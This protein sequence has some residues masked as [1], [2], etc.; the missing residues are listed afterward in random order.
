MAKL[1]PLE[2][3][4]Q[5]LGISPDRL[6][7]MRSR[8]EVFGYRDGSSWK[9][10][11]EELERVAREIGVSLGGKPVVEQDDLEDL[12][13]ADDLSLEI[14][15]EEVDVTSEDGPGDSES[16]SIL[17]S[18]EELGKSDETTA[19]TIIGDE[20]LSDEQSDLQAG[21]TAAGGS[22]LRLQSDSQIELAD[23]EAEL[24]PSDLLGTSDILADEGEKPTSPS[25]TARLQPLSGSGDELSVEP[26][27]GSID[28]SL[29][30]LDEPEGGEDEDRRDS[31]DLQAGNSGFGSAI[32][33]ELDDD[34]LVLGSGTGSDVTSG[35]GDSGINLN[36]PSDSGL[37]LEEPLDLASGSGVESLELGEDDL[38]ELDQVASGDSASG[39]ADDDFLLT[40][41]ESGLDDEGE[42]G[43]QV[44]DLD[45][46]EFDDSA[47]A[48][49]SPETAP[50]LE[51]EGASVE[52]TEVGEEE[53]PPGGLAVP[54]PGAPTADA[55]EAPYTIWNVLSLFFVALLLGFTGIL[56]LDL[57]NNIWSWD[58]NYAFNSQI[59]DAILGLLSGG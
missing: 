48:L 52:F 56:M 37:S 13:G 6:T 5:L 50:V 33:L 45:S 2:D 39:Q 1:I 42:S 4:A 24:D 43:S 17:V 49:L 41:V 40:P 32:D 38:A 20:L 53:A 51:E 21:E 23:E 22:E 16:D 55:V 58:G 36:H 35:A 47:A 9:F 15:E 12:V 59:M 44:I 57:M 18:E 30:D 10:K 27:S 26:D 34:E 11:M 28:L 8:N 19:S 54:K 14:D 3:A 25:D 29:D 31:A 46:E 7:E